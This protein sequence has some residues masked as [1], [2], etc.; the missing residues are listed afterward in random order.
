VCLGKPMSATGGNSPLIPQDEL[1]K[2]QVDP[3]GF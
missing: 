3:R 2:R 1:V